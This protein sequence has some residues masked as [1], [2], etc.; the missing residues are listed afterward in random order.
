ME[1]LLKEISK[2]ARA[3]RKALEPAEQWLNEDAFDDLGEAWDT[4]I[5]E[6]P[7]DWRRIGFIGWL[8]FD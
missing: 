8:A 6:L 2:F 5:N 7:R 1:K 4:A 3:N